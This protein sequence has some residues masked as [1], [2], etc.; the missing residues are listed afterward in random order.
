MAVY[1]MRPNSLLRV[2]WDILVG[3]AYFLCQWLDPFTLSDSFKNLIQFPT[4]N[5]LQ[6]ALT[7]FLVID[8]ATVPFKALLRKDCNTSQSQAKNTRLK[9]G[10]STGTLLNDPLFE[11]DV[12]LLCLSYLKSVF[13]F[14]F[15]ANVPIFVYE[16]S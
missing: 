6:R 14:D 1:T 16:T 10:R 15:L 13:I 8:M 12:K 5:K 2:I 9:I 11:R 3:I 7:I 4:M